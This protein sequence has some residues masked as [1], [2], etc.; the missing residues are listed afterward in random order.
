MKLTK[1]VAAVLIV[2]VGLNLWG[3]CGGSKEVI[4]PQS[5]TTTTTLGQE[6]QDLEEAYKKGAI[7]KDEYEAAKKKILEQRTKEK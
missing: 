6:L 7:T 1:T 4:V 3:C 2:V 5:Q